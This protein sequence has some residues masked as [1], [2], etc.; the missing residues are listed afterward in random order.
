MAKQLFHREK[1]RVSKFLRILLPGCHSP[2][3]SGQDGQAL[4][5]K[6]EQLRLFESVDQKRGAD[7]SAR[8]AE[9]EN[10]SP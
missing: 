5:M 7:C 1:L 3:G 6:K 4:Y 2:A 10:Q 8:R 9:M